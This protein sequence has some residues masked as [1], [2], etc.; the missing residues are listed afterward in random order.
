[1]TGQSGRQFRKASIKDV[2]RLAGVS[3]TTV[4]VFVS[5]RENV[6]SSETAA[7]IRAAV[8]ELNYTP[9]SLISGAQTRVTRTIGICIHNPLDPN[10]LYGNLFFE[11][12]WSGINLQADEDNYSL[13]HYPASVRDADNERIEPFLDGRVDGVIFHAHVNR[14]AELVAGAGMPT[15]LLTRSLNLPTGCGAAWADEKQTVGLA[16]SHLWDLGHR[17]I[18]HVAGPVGNAGRAPD[19]AR[20]YLSADDVATQRLR[21]YELWM[22][23]RGELRPEFVACAGS[24][25]G[26]HAHKIVAE[27]CKMAVPPTAVYC[28]NDSLAIAII[29]AA[30]AAGWS[31]PRDLSV[32]GTDN[33][34]PTLACQPAVTSIELANEQIGREGMRC[35]LRL[36]RGDPFDS[37]RVALPVSRLIERAST[38]APK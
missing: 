13:L 14:R 10:V 18:A 33:S 26:E 17:R 1:M 15:V 8:S 5:G 11:R 2:A 27:W 20:G 7:R 32:V 21:E 12:L 36:M 31:V 6:C 29:R 28:A 38:A 4:S 3:T 35:L 25:Q 37:C 22:G 9:S 16:L 30:Q 19:S 34:P 24:W 23:A